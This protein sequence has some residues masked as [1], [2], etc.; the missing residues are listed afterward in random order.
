MKDEK[1]CL[2]KFYKCSTCGKIIEI[3]KDPE[4]PTICCGH[5]ME[6]LI[7]NTTDGDHEKHVPVW[8]C[9]DN[10][11]T[12]K[13]GAEPHP[14]EGSHH[15]CWIELVT[16]EKIIRK[17]SFPCGISTASFHLHKNEKILAVYAYC[18]IHGLWADICCNKE[19]KEGEMNV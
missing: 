8:D 1:N 9:K 7:P 3:I 19:K 18:N 17:C 14:M 2:P 11:V 6:L 16:N 10:C 12:V 5:E 15:I 4:T 13:I